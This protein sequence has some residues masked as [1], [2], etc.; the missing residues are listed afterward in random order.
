MFKILYFTDIQISNKN[1]DIALNVFDQIIEV[2]KNEKPDIC[3]FGGDL[4]ENKRFLDD[5][6]MGDQ[7]FMESLFPFSKV[8]DKRVNGVFLEEYPV[9]LIGVPYRSDWEGM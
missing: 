8:L 9:N 2:S 1:L 3:I 5:S 6:V 7:H 4:F